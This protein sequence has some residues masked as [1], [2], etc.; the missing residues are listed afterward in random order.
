MK[1]RHTAEQSTVAVNKAVQIGKLGFGAVAFKK[2]NDVAPAAFAVPLQK[3][4]EV[5]VATE[6]DEPVF[7]GSPL[8]GNPDQTKI[9]LVAPIVLKKG[10]SEKEISQKEIGKKEPVGF[11]AV[12]IIPALHSTQNESKKGSHYQDVP[13]AAVL[14][15]RPKGFVSL[16][17]LNGNIKKD[18]SRNN[19][20]KQ[21]VPVDQRNNHRHPPPNSTNKT[22]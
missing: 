14:K 13:L 21:A 1:P 8:V 12:K 6:A 18:N 3:T 20:K 5:P 22:V 19:F 7:A 16:Q 17:N 9:N 2:K 11:S 10:A 4:L 15:N